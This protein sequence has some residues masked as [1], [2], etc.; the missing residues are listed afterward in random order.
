M[1]G[2]APNAKFMPVS[3]T[4]FSLKATE[5][6]F[7]YCTKTNADII[8]CSWGSTDPAFSLSAVKED[9]LTKA[10]TKGRN[11][12][13]CVILFAVGNDSKDYVNYYSA[14]PDVIAVGA[15]TSKDEH[16][17]YSNRGR[18][19]TVCAPSNGDWPIIAA[20]AWWDEGCDRFHWGC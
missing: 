17:T 4:S 15:T 2:S 1:V 16:A 18:E 9:V 19:V 6:M 12:K 10:A 7:E 3:G 11:G 8:S 13:G 20:R 5:E 14:H